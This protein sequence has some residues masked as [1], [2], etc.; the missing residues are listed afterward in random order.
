MA[1]FSGVSPFNQMPI[2]RERV[3]HRE[4]GEHMGG[5]FE[6]VSDSE[7]I[8]CV[9]HQFFAFDVKAPWPARW[10]NQTF[11]PNW[12]N[13]FNLFEF[14]QK[15]LLAVISGSGPHP[16]RDL[17]SDAH[18][19]ILAHRAYGLALGAIS[20]FI[21]ELRFEGDDH[22]LVGSTISS[23]KTNFWYLVT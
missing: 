1:A 18:T 19:A 21:S 4:P 20:N 16:E 2:E 13:R 5:I 3:E 23:V 10:I 17:H 11:N 12:G 8:E 15:D 6:S 9:I 14:A 7:L 22:G